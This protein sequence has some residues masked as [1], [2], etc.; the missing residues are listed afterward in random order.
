MKGICYILF[1]IAAF[2][3]LPCIMVGQN[4]GEWQEPCD[5]LVAGKSLRQGGVVGLCKSSNT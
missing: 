5:S 2:L 3:F 4:V 1:G